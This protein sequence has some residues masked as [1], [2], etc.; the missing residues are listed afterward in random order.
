MGQQRVARVGDMTTTGG[1][2]ITGENNVK[3]EGVAT[4]RIGDKASCPKS[5]VVPLYCAL[6]VSDVLE[7]YGNEGMTLRPNTLRNEIEQM[8]A[9]KK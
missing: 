3:S 8:E 1:K 5:S 6:F 4:A 2:I 7:N 9:Q